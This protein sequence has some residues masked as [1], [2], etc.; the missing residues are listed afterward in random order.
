[1]EG[2]LTTNAASFLDQI[3]SY[4]EQMPSMI[5]FVCEMMNDSTL[6]PNV[7][8]GVAQDVLVRQGVQYT[9]VLDKI[10][11]VMKSN[12]NDFF[13]R[14]GIRVPWSSLRGQSHRYDQHTL[15]F[16]LL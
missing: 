16:N 11:S 8:P 5:V 7:N 2:L 1:M 13:N 9:L 4:G 10:I 3:E 12:G 14:L 6:W 15:L